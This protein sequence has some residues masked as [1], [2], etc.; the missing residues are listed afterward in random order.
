MNRNG[1]VY[2]ALSAA[3]RT[4]IRR[5]KG[6]DHVH[7]TAYIHKSASVSRD[8]RAEE[9]AFVACGVHLD[10][11]VEIGRYSMLA[12]EV[13]VIGD[14]HVFDLVGVP[15]QFTGRPP[16]QR[17]VIGRDVWIGR[18]ALIRR[19]ITIGNGAIVGARSVVTSDVAP[20][21][22]VAGA[23]ARFIKQRFDEVQQQEHEAMLSGPVAARRVAERL[24]KAKNA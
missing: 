23:P 22:I 19:G 10:P 3:R 13:A 20:Y 15:M 18:G 11:R 16:Q 14:D 5:A 2:A 12:A 1:R 24:D 6:L 21:A 9:W 4:A 8:L 7:S 17:T